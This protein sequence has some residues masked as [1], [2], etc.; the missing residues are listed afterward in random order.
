MPLSSNGRTLK[1]VTLQRVHTAISN[2]IHKEEIRVQIPAVA[3]TLLAVV[4]WIE[5][6]TPNA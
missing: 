2:S 3:P 5:Q 4:Q 1:K 6:G